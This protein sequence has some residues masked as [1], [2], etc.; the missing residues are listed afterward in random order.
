MLMEVIVPFLIFGD[1]MHFI[2]PRFIV[3]PFT[4]FLFPT[5]FSIELPSFSGI[6]GQIKLIKYTQQL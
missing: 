3:V 5:A 4:G 6:A 2:Q 1:G